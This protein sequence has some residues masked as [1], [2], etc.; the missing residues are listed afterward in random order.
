MRKPITTTGPKFYI[1]IDRSVCE[2]I[3]RHAKE[4]ERWD[5]D[6]T[7]ESHDIHGFSVVK[8]K[9]G[10]DFILPYDPTGKTLYLV[11]AFYDTGDSFHREENKLDLVSLVDDY[12]DASTI[13]RYIET[14]Y[15]LF[16]ES[17][18]Y[19]YK[20]STVHLPHSKRNEEIYTSTWKGY[21]ERLREVRVE[22]LNA[23]MSVKF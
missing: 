8:E 20:P 5:G 18:K 21:F 1:K 15:K 4:G 6:D 19:D 22:T 13:L 10:W 9:D 14:D 17:D 23:G 16:Q 3:T 7:E 11:C 12:A 2:Q